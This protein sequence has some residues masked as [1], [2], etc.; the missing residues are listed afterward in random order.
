MDLL[1]KDY[2]GQASPS[3]W[4]YLFEANNWNNKATSTNV[5]LVFNVEFEQVFVYS[6]QT[7]L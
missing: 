1:L 4:E 2:E 3:L 5:F 6:F 7:Q